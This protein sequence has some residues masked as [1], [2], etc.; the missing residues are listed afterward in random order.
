M[1]RLPKVSQGVERPPPLPGRGWGGRSAPWR[2]WIFQHK[3]RP[4]CAPAPPP[5]LGPASPR[6]EVPP[7]RAPPL[8]LLCRSPQ[9]TCRTGYPVPGAGCNLLGPA[10]IPAGRTPIPFGSRAFP[11]ISPAPPAQVQPRDLATPGFG[12][13]ALP[14]RSRPHLPLPKLLSQSKSS[15]SQGFASSVRSGLPPSPNPHHPIERL[16][17][18]GCGCFP[19][20]SSKTILPPLLKASHLQGPIPRRIQPRPRP[21]LSP[22]LVRS[23]LSVLAPRVPDPPSS[24]EEEE[25]SSVVQ[26][27]E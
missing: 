20:L 9:R 13:T 3:H 10:P 21:E 1:L 12:P 22:A 11:K 24:G 26:A 15:S 23:A 6:A 8:L 5:S 19:A 27:H 17:A 25:A 16:K 2:S 14:P 7:S 4:P 18:C